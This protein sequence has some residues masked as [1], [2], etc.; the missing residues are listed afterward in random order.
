MKKILDQ[1]ESLSSH[2]GRR[3]RGNEQQTAAALRWLTIVSLSI[4]LALLVSGL[5]RH[6]NTQVLILA[7]GILPILLSLYLITRGKISLPSAILA[8]NLV[9]FVTWLTANGNGIYDAGVIAFPVILIVA[10]LILREQFIAYLTGLILLCLGWLV[11][12]DILDIYQPNY[13]TRSNAQDFFIISVVILV[14]SNSVYL[15][16]RNVH[17]NL[18]RAEQEIE[19]RKETEKQRE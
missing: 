19:A 17:Q 10:G 6:N 18:E 8:V 7:I 1:K 15:L 16:V 13:P 3:L 9:L 12:G 14:A 2:M 5:L 11:F 4:F